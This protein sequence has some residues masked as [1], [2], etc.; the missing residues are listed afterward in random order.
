MSKKAAEA[1]T[2]MKNALTKRE[3][4]VHIVIVAAIFALGIDLLAS[5]LFSQFL[6]GS[7]DSFYIGL[8]LIVIALSYL[9]I[10]VLR[11]RRSF[12]KYEGVIP[13]DK[14]KQRVTPIF[15]Y[16]LTTDMCR[17][18]EAVFLENEA[19][20]AAWKSE[21][22]VTQVVADAS[23]EPFENKNK[24]QDAKESSEP[25]YFAIVKGRKL[26]LTKPAAMLMEVMEFMVLEKLS[27]HLS[28]YFGRFDERDKQIMEH[29]REH[30]P[31][32]LLENRVLSLLSTPL[33]DR[34]IFARAKLPES[35]DGTIYT[36][37][38]TDGSMYSRFDLIL[39][40]G[41][42][43]KR[44]GPGVLLLDSRRV[45]LILKV[46]FEGYNANL[47]H[48]FEE[49]YMGIETNSVATFQVKVFLTTKVKPLAFLRRGGWKYY[50]W[51]DSFAEELEEFSDFSKFLKK[52]NW[53][54][55]M[56]QQ[57]I[58]SNLRKMREGKRS[59]RQDNGV[60]KSSPDQ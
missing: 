24:L 9:T 12:Y 33:E 6:S 47:P 36:I 29:N 1:L 14:N 28:S 54:S 45:S 41:T 15:G 42:I 55:A 2:G 51:V 3:E 7:F 4:I 30:V 22:P 46:E 13:I 48:G 23:D 8:G 34:A 43:V 37:Y 49:G 56:T 26:E 25:I 57:R 50:E 40:T 27:L 32:L 60:S 21:P 10:V 19:F 44:P 39:P 52:I 20:E 5:F 17:T 16:R 18:L 11:T 59:A 35:K 53:D 31:E 38:S 58:E